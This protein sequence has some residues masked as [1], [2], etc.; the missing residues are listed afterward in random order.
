MKRVVMIALLFTLIMSVQVFAHHHF[1]LP[2]PIYVES[3][4]PEASFVYIP[5]SAVIDQPDFADLAYLWAYNPESSEKMD[6]TAVAS[7]AAAASTDAN[8]QII[9]NR[10]RNN[11][12][13]L[14]SIR[15]KELA[16]T[17]YDSGDYDASATYAAESLRYAQMSDE[18][19][20]LQ[21]KIKEADDTIASAKEGMDWVVSKGLDKVYPSEWSRGQ[22]LYKDANDARAAEDY[23]GAIESARRILVLLD[24]GQ[25]VLPLPAQYTV[26]TWRGEKD[27]LWTIAGYSWVY[28]DSKKWRLLYD[29]NKSKFP[30]PNNPNWIEPGTV[31]DIPSVNNE[32]RFGAW[33]AGLSYPDLPR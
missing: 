18:Y 4:L 22:A 26:R 31:L 29:A 8:G 2:E 20:A 17:S 5:A 15:L 3:E 7:F 32:T 10:I 9:P 13:F 25:D 19:V 33:Q 14:E 12:Y 23:D 24:G 11:Q 27:C 16:D 1:D 21:L 28:G 6:F 30:E